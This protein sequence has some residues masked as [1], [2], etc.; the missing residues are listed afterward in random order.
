MGRAKL[1]QR[2]RALDIHAAAG[3]Q[4]AG[5]DAGSAGALHGLNLAAHAV[6]FIAGED[7]IAGA[8][9]NEHVNRDIENA[10]APPPSSPRGGVMPPRA[11]SAHKLDAIRAAFFG[12]QRR[13]ESFGTQLK[14]HRFHFGFQSKSPSLYLARTC[15]RSPFVCRV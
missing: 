13:F 6:K 1:D 11:R 5:G 10:Q 7:E 15:A 2:A 8:G 9:P 12:S 14:E 3:Q 4:N